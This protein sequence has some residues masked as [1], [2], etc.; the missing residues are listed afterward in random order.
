MR[1]FYTLT[2][3]AAALFAGGLSPA[4]AERQIVGGVAICIPE[5]NTAQ[6]DYWWIPSDLPKGGA[7]F[8]LDADFYQQHPQLRPLRDVRGRPSALYGLIESSEAY[9]NWWKPIPGSMYYERAKDPKALTEELDHTGLV[10]VYATHAKEQWVVWR[11]PPSA[12]AQAG[13]IPVVGE[14]VAVCRRPSLHW[15][16][17]PS[18]ICTRVLAMD[19]LAVMFPVASEDLGTIDLLDQ[20]VA[21]RVNAWRC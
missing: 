3:C 2:L 17:V 7:R 9:R 10:A 15:K 12:R 19:S 13:R 5:S 1:T 20:A 21:A 6:T 11:V 4:R 8:V 14:V 18:S 16:K